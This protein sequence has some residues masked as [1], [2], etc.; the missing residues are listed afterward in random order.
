MRINWFNGNEDLSEAFYIRK[1]V[2]VE[3]QNVPLALEMDEL[4]KDSYHVVIYDDE[5]IGTGRIIF[6]NGLCF[7]GRISILKSYRGKGIGNILVKEMIRKAF[8]LGVNEVHIHAQSHAEKFYEKLGF[9]IYGEKFY[10]ASIEHISM[11]IRK[12]DTDIN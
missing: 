10:E 3:E 9:E 8:S 12:I 1:K 11:V 4:D 6:Q 7:L 5:P 2:F